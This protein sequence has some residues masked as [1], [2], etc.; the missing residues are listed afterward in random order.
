MIFWDHG[1]KEVFFF[2]IL[3]IE[4][5][6]LFVKTRSDSPTTHREQGDYGVVAGSQ[7]NQ[8]EM[9][10]WEMGDG[11]ESVVDCFGWVLCFL[12]VYLFF[13]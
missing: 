2:L 6:C 7:V 12:K 9:G 8:V 11:M 1:I 3:L 13:V 4:G 10:C 5:C